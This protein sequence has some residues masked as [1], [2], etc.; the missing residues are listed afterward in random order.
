MVFG[1]YACDRGIKAGKIKLLLMDDTVSQNTLKEFNDAC[2]Y[3]NV[4]VIINKMP[5]KIGQ[6]VGKPANKVFGIVCPGFAG[7]LMEIH[8]DTFSGGV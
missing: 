2:A 8:K 4:S 5:R 7:R 1:A 6:A 3:Y